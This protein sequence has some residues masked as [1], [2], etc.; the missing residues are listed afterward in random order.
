MAKRDA[1]FKAI[2]DSLPGEQYHSVVSALTLFHEFLEQ[3]GATTSGRKKTRDLSLERF[4]SDTASKLRA[5][6]VAQIWEP[7]LRRELVD[8]VVVAFDRNW[9]DAATLKAAI[10][11]AKDKKREYERGGAGADSIWK[12]IASWI[13]GV[14]E[15][16]GVRWTPTA[17]AVE[18]RPR[19][20][21]E[22]RENET[23]GETIAVDA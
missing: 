3:G 15:A 18:P 6:L 2:L 11:Q 9:I 4:D 14:F 7:D 16:N 19:R 1:R 13:K 5:Q 21:R 12:P 20:R 17:S 8:R 22:K 23:T 10:A